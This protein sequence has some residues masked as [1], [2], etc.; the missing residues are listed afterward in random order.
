MLKAKKSSSRKVVKKTVKVKDESEQLK[1]HVVSGMQEK[2]AKEIVCIDMRNLKNA[3]TDFFIVCHADSRTHIE[4]IARS[5]EEYV[6]DKTKEDPLYKEGF[7]NAEWILLDYSNVVAHIF[8]KEKRDFFG[9][10]RLWA[11]AEIKQ[12]ASH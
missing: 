5:I 12:I 4:S 2:K 10:E 6:H 3:V 11:D 8:L 9:I 7:T 1:D